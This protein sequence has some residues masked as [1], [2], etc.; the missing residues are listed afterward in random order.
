MIDRIFTM[1]G[2]ALMVMVTAAP[3]MAFTAA[4]ATISW[5]GLVAAGAWV[6]KAFIHRENS[7]LPG[8]T[9]FQA[10]LTDAETPALPQQARDGP[11][12]LVPCGA[13]APTT[14][15][16]ETGH[17]RTTALVE[18]ALELANDC[19]RPGGAFIAKV[20]QG[21]STGAL[22]ARVKKS[23]HGVRHLKPPTHA[24]MFRAAKPVVPKRIVNSA[25]APS[26]ISSDVVMIGTLTSAGD[27]QIE[28]RVDGDVRCVRLIVGD[29]GEVN[30]NILAEDV[31][32]RGRVTGL[33]R[34]RSVFLCSASHVGGDILSETFAAE[35][36]AIFDGNCRHCDNPLAEARD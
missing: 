9:I 7:T 25:S 35:I 4:A 36:G 3:V 15:H 26:I 31:T 14:G 5:F 23:F 6:A 32:I 28:S 29:S 34:A 30:G 21:G 18:I 10:G 11:P 22:L 8:V 13:A 19:L 12:D 27:V 2:V 24:P 1:V 33:I 16:R 20:F 17:N